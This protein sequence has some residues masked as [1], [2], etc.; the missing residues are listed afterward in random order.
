MLGKQGGVLTTDI[1]RPD[2]SR[3]R[4]IKQ[5]FLSP[6][7]RGMEFAEIFSWPQDVY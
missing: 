2:F 6:F 3:K 5:P 7:H 1:F 4:Q